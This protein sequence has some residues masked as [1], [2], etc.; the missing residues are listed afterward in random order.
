MEIE[1]GYLGFYLYQGQSLTGTVGGRLYAKPHAPDQFECTVPSNLPLG[2]HFLYV[3]GLD[4]RGYPHMTAGKWTFACRS[5]GPVTVMPAFAPAP[6]FEPPAGKY[7]KALLVRVA[8][9]SPDASV[10][11]SIDGS[12]PVRPGGAVGGA[13]GGASALATAQQ[14]DARHEEDKG[15]ESDLAAR[16][17]LRDEEHAAASSHV[18]PVTRQVTIKARAYHI[19]L[20]PSPIATATYDL[21]PPKALNKHALGGEG[22]DYETKEVMY[23]QGLRR[24]PQDAGIL[25]NY[26]CFLQHVRCA[27]DDAEKVFQEALQHVPHHVCTLCNYGTLLHE[28]RGDEAGALRMYRR[29]LQ[30]DPNHVTSLFNL[31][32]LLKK[33]GADYDEAESVYKR[34]LRLEPK[35]V[36]TLCNY[37]AFLF[38]VR[39]EA[40]VAE[41]VYQQA[42]LLQPADAPV[43][44]NYALLLNT[45]RKDYDAAEFMYRTAL[46]HDPLDPTTLSNYG[47][48]LESVRHDYSAAEHH[49]KHA[50]T[51]EPTHIQ[52]IC[53]YATFLTS[54][55]RDYERAVVLLS[56]APYQPPIVQCLD[57]V[58]A[59]R[60]QQ[61]KKKKV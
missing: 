56:R 30:A 16:S 58:R 31:A 52:A 2:E 44:C 48:F 12:D 24:S 21:E 3:V 11:V 43:L 28:V 35:D 27:Y 55:K 32:A 15:D 17:H 54:V 42:L 39:H 37:G 13:A 51:L 41:R 10:Y 14:A 38:E 59:Q 22:E 29:A 25:S 36:G 61:G 23:L 47:R 6:T 57:W 19:G 33:D 60:E 18:I 20:A 1:G 40:D 50:I 45:H 5:M 49:Y 8:A 4:R 9:S 53:N 34:L 26:A 7:S 46:E